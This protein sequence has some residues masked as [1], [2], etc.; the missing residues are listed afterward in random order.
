MRRYGRPKV[1]D[2]AAASLCRVLLVNGG[3]AYSAGTVSR[4]K[5]GTNHRPATPATL[6]S[7]LSASAQPVLYISE[8]EH[9]ED[10]AREVGIP[11]H[12]LKQWQPT[13][14]ASARPICGCLAPPTRPVRHHFPMLVACRFFAP[15]LPSRSPP[16]GG[17]CQSRM[18]VAPFRPAG[19]L[20][21]QPILCVPGDQNLLV[22]SR[23]KPPSSPGQ[24][25]RHF[26]V[27]VN[28]PL[29]MASETIKSILD[30][31]GILW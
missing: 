11:T 31:M 25:R 19:H 5:A 21:R 29:W 1:G 14:S 30:A 22:T 28:V 3:A 24:K 15:S 7:L 8:L 4:E 10:D 23:I 26:D 12:R 9:I 6:G 17:R 20:P 2:V 16:R 13:S 27:M 18:R